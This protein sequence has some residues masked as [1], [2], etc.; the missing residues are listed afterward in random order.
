MYA[1]HAAMPIG[2]RSVFSARLLPIHRG[3]GF[4][5]HFRALRAE[6]GGIV[7]VGASARTNGD[8]PALPPKVAPE[9][10]AR[11]REFC[12]STVALT[13]NIAL[14]RTGRHAARFSVSVGAA[15]RLA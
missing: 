12:V 13:S 10:S 7:I 15:R 1:V 11:D 5:A 3:S 9:S 2:S 4:G 6:F 8:V 14:N